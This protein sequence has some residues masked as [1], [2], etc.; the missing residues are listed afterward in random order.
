MGLQR[1][2]K[3]MDKNGNGYLEFPEFHSMVVMITL[4][5]AFK[6]IDQDGSGKIR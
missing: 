4:V 3:A 2:M 6:K 5:E 1:F